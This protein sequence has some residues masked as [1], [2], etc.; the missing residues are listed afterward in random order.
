LE[1]KILNVIDKSVFVSVSNPACRSFI[2]W[3]YFAIKKQ[4]VQTFYA[5]ADHMRQHLDLNI[6][7]IGK[8]ICR[9]DIEHFQSAIS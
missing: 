7:S 3:L 1:V 8:S 5:E 4:V 6:E 9:S 2:H